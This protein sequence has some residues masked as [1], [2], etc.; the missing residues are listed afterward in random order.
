ML[1][2]IEL[3]MELPEPHAQKLR[4]QAEVDFELDSLAVMEAM[5]HAESVTVQDIEFR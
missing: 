1:V 5:G 2:H 4:D 3:D